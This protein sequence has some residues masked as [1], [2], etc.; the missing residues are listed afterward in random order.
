MSPEACTIH[1]LSPVD[2]KKYPVKIRLYSHCFSIIFSLLP[3]GH[4]IFLYSY[5]TGFSGFRLYFFRIYYLFDI[6]KCFAGH[7]EL[8]VKV[9]SV[10]LKIIKDNVLL[11]FIELT[12][13]GWLRESFVI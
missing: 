1:F 8:P 2:A 10:N 12:Y 5:L 6:D 13:C 9:I 4:R 7:T 3:L 11:E